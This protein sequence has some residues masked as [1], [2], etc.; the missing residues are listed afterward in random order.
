[1]NQENL[2]LTEVW[3]NRFSK[4]T[5]AYRNFEGLHVL[6]LVGNY[7]QRALQHAEFLQDHIH[8]GPIHTLSEVNT[9]ILKRSEG[10]LAHPLVN[11]IIVDL[12]SKTIMKILE[13]SVKKNAP[14]FY[15]AMQ[16]LSEHTNYAPSV[17]RNALFQA[18]GIMLLTRMAMMKYLTKDVPPLCYPGCSS[19]VAFN[20]YTKNRRMIIA[21]NQ[22][23]PIVGP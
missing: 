5:P 20:A 17:F 19:A 23:Y 7:E 18:D 12:F 10:V 15:K 4:Q 2:K 6:K 13:R 1:M 9:W 14:H 22:D 11:K 8:S 21:R 3:E 16:I